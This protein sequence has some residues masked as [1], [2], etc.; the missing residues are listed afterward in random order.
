MPI[1]K[2]EVA[3]YESFKRLLI[4]FIRRNAFLP[5]VIGIHISVHICIYVMHSYS[6]KMEVMPTFQNDDNYCDGVVSVFEYTGAVKE[7]LIRF[8]FYNEPSYYKPMKLIDDRLNKL[9]T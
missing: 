3:E 4:L 9:L 8:K 1:Y 2:L 7:S 6:L 5:R